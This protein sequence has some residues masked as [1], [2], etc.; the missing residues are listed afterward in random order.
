[1]LLDLGE[2]MTPFRDDLADLAQS[3]ALILGRTRC[4]V[5][6]FNGDPGTAAGWDRTGPGRTWRP[7]PGRPVVLA[8]DFGL[9]APP[10]ARVR[11]QSSAWQRFVRQVRSGGCP[12]VAFVPLP[13][14]LWPLRLARDISLIHWDPRTRAGAVRRLVGAGHARP[15]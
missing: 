5:S 10:T 12:I 8:T 4:Q 15:Q 14:G 2:S 11:G 3:F 9:G 7:E 1:L 6:E 13:P